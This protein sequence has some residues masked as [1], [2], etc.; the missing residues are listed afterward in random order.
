[1]RDCRIFIWDIQY[2]LNKFMVTHNLLRIA[3][4]LRMHSIIDGGALAAIGALC[5][6]HT[7]FDFHILLLFI[8]GLLYLAWGMG[9][10]EICDVEYDQRTNINKILVRGDLS[11]EDAKRIV[12][13][14]FLTATII[15][16]YLAYPSLIAISILVALIISGAGYDRFSKKTAWA[17]F[18]AG[19]WMFFLILFGAAVVGTPNLFALCIALYCALYMVEACSIQGSIKDIATDPPANVA[20]AL[21]SYTYADVSVYLSPSFKALSIFIKAMQIVVF[22]TVLLYL[23]PNLNIT[24]HVVFLTLLGATIFTFTKYM[25]FSSLGQRE[26]LKRYLTLSA[27]FAFSLIG[28]TL[29]AFVSV[30][31]LLL[32]LVVSLIWLFAWSYLVTGAVLGTRH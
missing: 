15:G 30:Y 24:F 18:F 4:L 9:F 28:F 12:I 11:I 8:F 32:L 27:V 31:E 20:L 14:V 21:G 16:I 10:N 3:E 29:I 13:T 23:L 5:I 1:M 19:A 26:S 2:P 6:T 7:I 17:G 25:T 22:F